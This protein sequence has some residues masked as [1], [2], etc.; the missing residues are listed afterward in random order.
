MCQ[1]KKTDELDPKKWIESL[2]DKVRLS[3]KTKHS[4]ENLPVNTEPPPFPSKIRF[5]NTTDPS[6]PD[7]FIPQPLQE[8]LTLP[9][10]NVNP[11]NI[12]N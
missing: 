4:K 7:Y 3:N 1:F 10:A 2:P 5:M 8:T 11:V 12:V 9:S 6:R